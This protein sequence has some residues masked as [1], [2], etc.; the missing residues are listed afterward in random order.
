MRLPFVPLA[1]WLDSCLEDLLIGLMTVID[2]PEILLL[3]VPPI[4]NRSL[5]RIGRRSR[6]MLE[7]SSLTVSTTANQS[8][9]EAG[10]ISEATEEC[11][12]LWT[13]FQLAYRW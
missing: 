12:E 8:I 7:P 3:L 6:Y 1:D 10:Y 9:L 13:S 2:M 5:D 4:S 11:P